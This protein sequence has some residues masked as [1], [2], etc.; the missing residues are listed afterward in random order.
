MTL[1]FPSKKHCRGK[2]AKHTDSGTG[3]KL[4]LAAEGKK[5]K[6]PLLEIS[7]GANRKL[8][9]HE[10]EN[11][12]RNTDS[13]SITTMFPDS[14]PTYFS[15]GAQ[16]T[17]HSATR[18][19]ANPVD[20]EIHF[21]ASEKRS[22]I[23]W[24]LQAVA[25]CLHEWNSCKRLKTHLSKKGSNARHTLGTLGRLQEGTCQ[26]FPKETMQKRDFRHCAA[27]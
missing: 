12:L 1:E 9:G 15:H 24:D 8:A 6:S 14:G 18:P 2:A 16:I 3:S 22:G 11:L 10:M 20:I 7:T 5:S 13:T 19:R 21:A 4:G 26:N 17:A 25:D 27:S 23:R